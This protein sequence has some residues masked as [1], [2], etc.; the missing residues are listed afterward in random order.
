VGSVNADGSVQL[1][2]D[3]TTTAGAMLLRGAVTVPF[4]GT[5]TDEV[6]V[7]NGIALTLNGPE[8]D[9]TN[10]G[11]Q[12]GRSVSLNSSGSVNLSSGRS[13]GEDSGALKNLVLGTVNIGDGGQIESGALAMN[14][15]FTLSG[16][17]LVVQSG[18]LSLT[19]TLTQ[20]GGSLDVN[21]GAL[22]LDG[23]LTL[24]GG[25]MR[26]T[27]GLITL[28]ELLAL[29]GGNLQLVSTAARTITKPGDE[30]AGKLAGALPV[31]Y[32]DDVVVQRAGR[33]DLGETASLSVVSTQGGSIKLDAVGSGGEAVNRFAGVLAVRSGAENSAW[34][35]NKTAATFDGRPA[36]YALQ[37]R[38]RIDGS[39]VRIGRG[40]VDIGG[41]SQGIAGIEADVVSIRA[42]RLT[43]DAATGDA[44]RA[45]IAAR[46]PFDNTVGTENSV[47]GLTL[48]L[49]PAAFD[50]AFPFGQS[51]DSREIFINVGSRA[52]GSPTRELPLDAG[53]L[54]V[55]PRG[56][57]KGSTA[58]VLSG[59]SL[60]AG[61]QFFFDGAGQQTEIP[62]FYNGVLPV[63]PQVSGSISAT[64]SVSESAR[65]ER[66]EEA[67]R[68]ENVALR[69]RAGV[70]A[71]VGPGRP[72]TQGSEGAAAP[73]GC[74][75]E[76]G[77]LSCAGGK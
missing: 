18:D 38:V 24:A 73:L 3:L 76:V 50:L 5:R 71:E 47:A 56:G 20:S 12:W 21:A 55:L 8:I 16:G 61:Y 40:A 60:G 22:T 23:A 67:V 64:V 6:A 69:L 52:W 26:F 31:A 19:G 25:A 65:K 14:G 63:T 33:I 36:N 28:N 27:A 62:V 70:I 4:T 46:L 74:A 10:P 37:G 49:A 7:T 43:T 15:A 45:A 53:Y 41:A 48:S 72:A 34:D 44:P 59:P 51:G 58:V 66:F 29:S 68:T 2:G 35:A 32:A 9:A 30:L 42:E 1:G 75:P 54:Q 77:S 57:A 39:T 11:N 17:S 13:G